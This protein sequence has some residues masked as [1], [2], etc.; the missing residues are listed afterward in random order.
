VTG[1]TRKLR[2]GEYVITRGASSK[3]EK[4]DCKRVMRANGC[5]SVRFELLADGRMSVH[6]YMAQMHDQGSPEFESV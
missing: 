1:Q 3:E 4:A 5:R 6:G 2:T